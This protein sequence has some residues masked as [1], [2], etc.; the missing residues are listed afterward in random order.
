MAEIVALVKV[1]IFA[2]T[3]NTNEASPLLVTAQR[4]K[5]W[6]ALAGATQSSSVVDVLE[7]LEGAELRDILFEPPL[8]GEASSAKLKQPVS[9]TAQ[10]G[11]L[12]VVMDNKSDAM[13]CR[14]SRP[15][16]RNLLFIA[17]FERMDGFLKK[18]VS[19]G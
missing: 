16:N 4:S 12:V 17:V 5:V 8:F 19:I 6:F 13:S 18:L 3:P 14:N 10:V 7:V 9:V 1:F 15:S 2:G 11:K